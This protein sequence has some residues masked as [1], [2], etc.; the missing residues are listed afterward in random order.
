M[1]DKMDK[2]SV[3]YVMNGFSQPIIRRQNYIID[4]V[5][6]GGNIAARFL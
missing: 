6:P 5:E 1:L 2:L 3:L 4:T